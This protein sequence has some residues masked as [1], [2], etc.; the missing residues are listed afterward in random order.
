MRY[1]KSDPV[2]L[3]IPRQIFAQANFRDINFDVVLFLQI[4]TPRFLARIYF[5]NWKNS[6]LKALVFWEKEKTIKR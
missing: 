3:V 2:F 6:F 5:H 4:A 1:W